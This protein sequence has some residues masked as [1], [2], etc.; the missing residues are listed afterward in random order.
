VAAPAPHTLFPALIFSATFSPT[1]VVARSGPLAL[2]FSAPNLSHLRRSATVWSTTDFCSTRLVRRVIYPT[3]SHS[4]QIHSPKSAKRPAH[5]DFFAVLVH[6]VLN[7]RPDAVLVD[8]VLVLRVLCAR[9]ISGSVAI[10]G[11][12][13]PAS[14]SSS[15]QDV[16]AGVW[17]ATRPGI[18]SDGGVV[19]IL[20]E[21]AP[22]WRNTAT[23]WLQLDS[24]TD[25][26]PHHPGSR[27][28]FVFGCL[29][30]ATSRS[31]LSGPHFRLVADL[32]EHTGLSTGTCGRH[33][34]LG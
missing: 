15:A 2:P 10:A 20:W 19:K 8:K 3:P 13:K 34:P 7:R 23:Q 21:V 11:A 25:A 1:V 17:S 12:D 4:I 5:L 22:V 32:G 30:R 29:S 27:A 16:F 9:A 24:L 31:Y 14:S 33:G 26:V 28:E 6:R 18:L